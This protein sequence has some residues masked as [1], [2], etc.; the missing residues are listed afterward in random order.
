MTLG[1]FRILPCMIWRRL[2]RIRCLFQP[3]GIEERRTTASSDHIDPFLTSSGTRDVAEACIDVLVTL[4]AIVRWSP[5]T[6]S[7][8]DEHT[9]S[10]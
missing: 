6:A 7:S 4:L 2:S 10:V 1:I 9:Q 3:R 8:Y 5:V